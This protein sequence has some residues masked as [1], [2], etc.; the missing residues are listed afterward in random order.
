LQN[1]LDLAVSFYLSTLA[2][3]STFEP[4]SDRLLAI[5]C[6]ANEVEYY[7]DSEDDDDVIYIRTT[8]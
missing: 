5:T 8:S 3:Q 2:L 6:K 7:S 4:A 1:E